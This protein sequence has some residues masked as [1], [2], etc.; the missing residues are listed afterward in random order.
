MQLEAEGFTVLYAASAEARLRLAVEQP[1]SLITLDIMLPNMDGWEFLSRLKQMPR[2]PP[3][4]GRHHFDRADRNKGF[5][6]G[7]AA[8]MQKP[9]PRENLYES[10]VD[11][12]LCPSATARSLK[13][14]VVDDDPNAV[15]L[16]AVRI[17]GLAT[18]SCARSAAGRQSSRRDGSCPDLI[19]LDLMMPDVN[20]FDV[21]DALNDHPDTARIPI[22]V[23][24]AKPITT[25]DRAKLQ[26]YV[27][28]IM[29]KAT[30][31]RHRLTA[32]VRRAMRRAS[33][34]T[35]MAT[36]LVVEDNAANMTLAIFLLQSAGHTVLSATDGEAALTLARDE[37]PDLI[38]MDIQL[39]G[40]DGLAA[41]VLLKRTTRRTPFR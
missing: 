1:L 38:L 27:T 15:E 41:T 39:P 11:L 32:E 4:P 2:P 19:V 13:V 16:I 3:Y 18:Q 34:A 29:Q 8:V 36:V 20:G 10:L 14:L 12:A 28:T 9:I 21:V 22:L 23:V 40:M 30:F 5:S 31:D 7:A 17:I 26:G 6:L 33:A 37:Q 25:E 35:E 24:T